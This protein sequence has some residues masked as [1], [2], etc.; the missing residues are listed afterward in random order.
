LQFGEAATL[1]TMLPEVA[2]ASEAALKS[3]VIV[4]ATL[5]ERLVYDTRPLTAA[6]IVAPCRTPLP[7]LREAV[8]SVLLS[9]AMRLPKAS[10]IRITGCWRRRFR[11]WRPPK[12]ELQS[13]GG[14]P[15]RG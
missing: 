7:A 1:T 12:A 8:T 5:W 2:P 15:Q 9:P 10:S 13:S 11:L 4:V 3:M 14:W 6:M